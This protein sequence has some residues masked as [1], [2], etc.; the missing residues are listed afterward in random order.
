M[1]V[2]CRR[3]GGPGLRSK[4]SDGGHL[5]FAL[6]AALTWTGLMVPFHQHPSTETPVYN[7]YRYIED[8]RGKDIQ[9]GTRQSSTDDDSETTALTKAPSAK[10]GQGRSES[11]SGH[12]E[13]HVGYG[14]ATPTEA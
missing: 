12:H 2:A 1:T 11:M 5:D 13:Q 10:T 6:V 3:V 8:G 14:S 9:G 4:H 7:Y